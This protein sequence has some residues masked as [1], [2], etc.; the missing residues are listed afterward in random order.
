M[1]EMPRS[2]WALT[3]TDL[4]PLLFELSESLCVAATLDESVNTP[5]AVGV[6]V[7]YA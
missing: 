1:L 6:T 5:P 2:I 3:V 4:L 7:M